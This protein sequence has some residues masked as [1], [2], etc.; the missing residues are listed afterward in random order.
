MGSQGLQEKISSTEEGQG[1]A[2]AEMVTGPLR[3][4]KA[5]QSTKRAHPWSE[6]FLE[7]PLVLS[8]AT[9]RETP[10]HVNIQLKS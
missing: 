9:Q 2:D 8:P 4:R 6:C 1:E 10:C 5:G 7:V 3:E